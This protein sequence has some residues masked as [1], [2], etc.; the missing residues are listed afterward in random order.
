MQ[1]VYFVAESDIVFIYSSSG[2][3]LLRSISQKMSAPWLFTASLSSPSGVF[4]IVCA[5]ISKVYTR[6][7][8]EGLEPTTFLL[9]MK[10]CDGHRGE[11]RGKVEEFE[12]LFRIR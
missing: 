11:S 8:E 10:P 7:H 4:E 6:P 9:P 3:L 5:N 12:N 1:Y 2:R